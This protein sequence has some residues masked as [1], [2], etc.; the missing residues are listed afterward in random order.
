M[1]IYLYIFVTHKIN[2]KKLYF[3]LGSCKKYQ[4]PNLVSKVYNSTVY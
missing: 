3:N 1:I 2:E 4:V